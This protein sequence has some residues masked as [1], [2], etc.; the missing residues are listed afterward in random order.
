MSKEQ[1]LSPSVWW[2][3]L[4]ESS[5]SLRRCR[6]DNNRQLDRQATFG[7]LLLSILLDDAGP[8]KS[9]SENS[10][11][12]RTRLLVT[13]LQKVCTESVDHTLERGCCCRPCVIMLLCHCCTTFDWYYETITCNS[14]NSMVTVLAMT[15]AAKTAA[16]RKPG[17]TV[18]LACVLIELPTQLLLLRAPKSLMV[19]PTSQITSRPYRDGYP[20][21]PR[22]DAPKFH[23]ASSD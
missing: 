7:I 10:V 8:V 18:L 11:V 19:V 17:A 13:D 1:K 16:C 20:S 23:D 9:H 3:V 14:T 4:L 15:S 21:R 6:N 12:G 22:L 5:H 2:L